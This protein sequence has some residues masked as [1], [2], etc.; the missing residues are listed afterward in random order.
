MSAVTEFVDF[1]TTASNWTGPKGLLTLTANQILVS[2]VAVVAAIIVA[3]PAGL[4][5]GHTRRGGLSAVA[6]ANIGRA[7]PSFAVLVLAFG[8]FSQWG[9]GLSVWPTTVALFL[10]AI[11][12]VFTNTLT[13]VRDVDTRVTD[14]AAAMGMRRHQVLW[15]VQAPL[16]VPMVLTG[17]RVSASQVVATA[18]LGAWVGFQCLGTL[19]F[20]GFAQ[21]ND[22]K[23]LTGAVMVS[24]LTIATELL[25]GLVERR[26]SPWSTSGGDGPTDQP[27]QPTLIPPASTTPVH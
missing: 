6:V 13:A 10:L 22:A 1:I 4:V 14:A 27:P 15:R 25:F 17:I 12:P 2:V 24:L 19:I 9:R 5:L 16:A 8:V 20:E 11:P 18:T 7:L 3:V 26:V 23:I 21:R